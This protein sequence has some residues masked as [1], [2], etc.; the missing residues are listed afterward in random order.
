MDFYVTYYTSFSFFLN[1]NSS[2][3]GEQFPV[4]D[5]FL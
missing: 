2:D 5:L 3:P 4:A 1:N